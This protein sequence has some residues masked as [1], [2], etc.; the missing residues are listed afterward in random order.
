MNVASV[1]TESKYVLCDGAGQ[2][3]SW[4]T[5]EKN[6]SDTGNR[7][8]GYRVRGDNVSHYTISDYL[9]RSYKVSCSFKR[10]GRTSGPRRSGLGTLDAVGNVVDA[11]FL[12]VAWPPNDV[13]FPT[14]YHLP[15]TPFLDFSSPLMITLG[16]VLSGPSLFL[17][18]RLRLLRH[19]LRNGLSIHDIGLEYRAWPWIHRHSSSVALRPKVSSIL[20][21][22]MVSLSPGTSACPCNVEHN[23]TVQADAA[24]VVGKS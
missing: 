1:M 13:G 14:W 23:G 22:E 11:L 12:D 9:W 10:I 17:F 3:S 16:T 24:Y 21:D 6:D 19:R 15:Q 2:A 18:I 5:R 7:T 8:P 20:P 4:G